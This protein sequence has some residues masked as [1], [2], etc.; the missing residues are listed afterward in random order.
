MT[1]IDGSDNLHKTIL[2]Q[3][4]VQINSKYLPV[5]FLWQGVNN[6]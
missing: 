3:L 6:K 1:V 4:Q 2:L 5:F